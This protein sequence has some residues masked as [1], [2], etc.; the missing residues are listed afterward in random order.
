[1][2]AISGFAKPSMCAAPNRCRCRSGNVSSASC[3]ASSRARAAAALCAFARVGGFGDILE[4]GHRGLRFA[5][6]V[7]C[8]GWPFTP[9][10]R[11]QPSPRRPRQSGAI[12]IGAS[13]RLGSRLRPSASVGLTNNERRDPKMPPESTVPSTK[14][15]AAASPP[16][17]S[18]SSKGTFGVGPALSAS[19]SIEAYSI[20]TGGS[21][22]GRAIQARPQALPYSFAGACRSN[23][24]WSCLHVFCPGLPCRLLP[25]LPVWP[26]RLPWM[27]AT[28]TGFGKF[29]GA[30]RPFL[31]VVQLSIISAGCGRPPISSHRQ[32]A[33]LCRCQL[34][35]HH[36]A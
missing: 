5:A 9:Y 20:E 2:V 3:K 25:S 28:H 12:F 11:G 19:R 16:H 17:I 4:A 13:A 26:P 29:L 1:M 23:R 6:D 18:R 15:A 24:T 33:R 10:N 27:F 31:S 14:R 36:L 22:C 32:L 30:Q 35:S 21:V 8:T 7:R 34:R